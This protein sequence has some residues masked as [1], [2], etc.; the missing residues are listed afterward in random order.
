MHCDRLELVRSSLQRDG[1]PH[2]STRCHVDG[3]RCGLEADAGDAEAVTTGCE[4][5]PRNAVR[6][7]QLLV[8]LTSDLGFGEWVAG[9]AF[10]G[11]DDVPRRWFTLSQEKRGEAGEGEEGQDQESHA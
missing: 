10:D 3:E 7:G 8:R 9:F 4:G 1:H 6:V 11:D 2:L 5:E